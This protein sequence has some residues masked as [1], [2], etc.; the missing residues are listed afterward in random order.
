MAV[1]FL[2][3]EEAKSGFEV[4]RVGNFLIRFE[5][6]SSTSG[7]IRDVLS[8]L[9]IMGGKYTPVNSVSYKYIGQKTT[10]ITLGANTV[11]I[12]SQLL[13]PDVLNL[14]LLEDNNESLFKALNTWIKATSLY[15]TGRTPRKPLVNSL[16]IKIYHL[17]IGSG[18]LS[19]VSTDMFN[20]A[21]PDELQKS[22]TQG[23]STKKHSVAFKILGS[24]DF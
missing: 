7:T 6:N 23:V 3:L 5:Y 15:R 11:P 10:D 18:G 22:N 14:E 21:P 9:N 8:G 1:E 13:L 17:D 2:T 19:V 4:G 24:F 12:G 16:T 20:I